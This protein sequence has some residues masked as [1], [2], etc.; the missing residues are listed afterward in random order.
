MANSFADPLGT[1]VVHELSHRLTPAITWHVFHLFEQSGLAWAAGESLLMQLPPDIDLTANQHSDPT[2]RQLYF[3]PCNI[4]S[5]CTA[6][7]QKLEFILR[8]G[9]LSSLIG[10]PRFNGLQASIWSVGHGFDLQAWDRDD[11]QIIAIAGG[12]GISPFLAISQSLI[13]ANSE[14]SLFWCLHVGDLSLVRYVLENNHLS[15]RDWE[16]VVIFVSVGTDTMTT[17]SVENTC[18]ELW[19]H[20][21]SNIQEKVEFRCRRMTEMDIRAV[22]SAPKTVSIEN[23]T[24]YFCGSKS[25]QWQIKRW[26]VGINA[27]VVTIPNPDI[28]SPNK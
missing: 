7:V 11:T 28:N 5:Q 18:R 19:S 16:G 9:R 6:G 13:S 3:T 15:V 24:L 2:S 10:T 26:G 17:Y 1:S 27:K 23:T 21:P 22:Q 4:S 8:N 12:T 20:L 14:R 25:L